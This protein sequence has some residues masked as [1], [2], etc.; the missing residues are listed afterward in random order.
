MN[1]EQ[2][3]TRPVLKCGPNDTLAIAAQLMWECESGCVVVVAEG[4][5]VGII[6][7]RDVA[8]GAYTSG[9]ALWEVPVLRSMTPAPATIREDATIDA[10]ERLMREHHVR[11]LPVVDR[12]RS[13]VG[14]ISLDDIAREAKNQYGRKDTDV[15]PDGVAATLAVVSEPRKP[16]AIASTL[17]NGKR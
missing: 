5:V 17:P 1:V 3:M 16:Q 10:A 15:T 13:L 8:M 4:V 12:T 9:Q 7:D 11:R 6:T 2:V 14:L